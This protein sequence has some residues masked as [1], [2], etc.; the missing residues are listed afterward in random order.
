MVVNIKEFTDMKHNF[1]SG[2]RSCSGC[3]FPIIVRTIMKACKHPVIVANATGCLE[4]TSTIYP[5][6]SWNVPY[7]HNT[8]ENAAATLSG[9]E[10]AYKAL[11]RKGKIKKNI[12]F[13]AF[14]GDGGCYSEDTE[15]FT[16]RGFIPIKNMKVGEK[17][18]SV[19]PQNN[20]LELTQIEK[21]FKYKVDGKMIRVKTRY[22]DFLVTPDHNVPIKF[23]NKYEFI[24]ASELLTRY[25]T[26]FNRSFRWK[27]KKLKHY[28]LP[29]F[30]RKTNAK[31]FSRFK[32]KDW[33]RF[34]GW[35]ISEGTLYKSKSGY[36]VRIYQSNKKNRKEILNLL[37][38]MGVGAFECNRSIDFQSKQIYDIL[39]KEC[40][41]YS[42]GRRI[43][44]W[45]LD[46]NKSLLKY[47][48]ETLM[49]GDG[50]I[51]IQKN[52]NKPKLTYITISKKLMN[53][54]VELVFKFGYI[55]NVHLEDRSIYRIGISKQH[56]HHHIYSKR[57][58]YERQ[59]H[60]QVWEEKYKGMVYCPQL[61]KNHT[62]IIKRH[63]KISL[64]GNSYDI[65][66]QSISG[67]MERMHDIVYV[68]Y[69]NGQYANTGAQRSSATPCGAKTSTTPVG[70]VHK[71]KELFRK[72][73]TKIMVS[74]NIPYVAQAAVHNWSDLYKKAK[75]AFETKGPA[76]LNVLSTCTL[77]W[78]HA[79]NMTIEVSKRAV[80]SNFWPLYEVED[81]KYKLNYNPAK[82]I[83]VS[84]F[85]RLQ[86]RFKHLL[87]PENQSIL[88]KVQEHTDKKWEELLKLCKAKSLAKK[89]ENLPKHF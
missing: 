70:K 42:K 47:I 8:F 55:G 30:K 26:P 52:R 78:K 49:K 50:S 44:A 57:N 12:K 87:I 61:H 24:N 6:T 5:Y 11:K 48:Y 22:I 58:L 34:L 35:F 75:K 18:W 4:V 79:T 65:G 17:I 62:V 73:L 67:A 81:G 82:P 37:K 23:K 68:C 31:V 28:I 71:G 39:L 29:K 56:L 63:N 9:V 85:F 21:I 64:N 59:G 60:K 72:D 16:E 84:D 74:H 88:D 86:G 76:F 36:L 38:N 15:I 43:P 66:L 10:S 54:F 53:N 27:G 13:I 33:L 41:K 32:I 19:N 7:I 14:G 40:G 20:E 83:P 51:S 3:A 2:H 77:N 45:V 69:D 25:K 1:V 89:L 46:L 80:N